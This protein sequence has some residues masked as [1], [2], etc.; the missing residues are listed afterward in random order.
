V[1]GVPTAENLERLAGLLAD[2]ALRVPIQGGYP[3]AQAGQAL[4]TLTGQHT[5]G[6]LAI[7][8]P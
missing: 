2:G 8:I 3:L 1:M 4:Q 7:T 5:Q 6:K